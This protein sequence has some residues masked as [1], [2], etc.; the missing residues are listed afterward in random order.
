M[1][2][3]LTPQEQAARQ[4]IEANADIDRAAIVA[5]EISAMVV[6]RLNEAGITVGTHLAAQALIAHASLNTAATWW[7]SMRRD[8]PLPVA[9]AGLLDFVINLPI[10]LEGTTVD[11]RTGREME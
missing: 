9:F 2:L 1:Q 6:E 10:E 3:K 7:T 4:F 5:T 11:L 8:V